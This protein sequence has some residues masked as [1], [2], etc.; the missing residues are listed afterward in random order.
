MVNHPV[1]LSFSD[2]RQGDQYYFV[3]D[4]ARLTAETGWQA[5]TGWREGLA[6]LAAWLRANRSF[7]EREAL[8]V[9]A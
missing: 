1:P 7:P 3:A 2:W 5:R 8:R 6:D 9:R 4:T